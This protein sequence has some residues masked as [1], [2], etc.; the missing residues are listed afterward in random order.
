M[1]RL[2][3]EEVGR[4]FLRWYAPYQFPN[5]KVPCCVD[6]R[7]DDP[8]PENDSHGEFIFLVSELYRYTH[9][10]SLLEAMWPHVEAAAGYMETLRQSERSA[11]NHAPARRAFYGL[12][13]ASISHEPWRKAM[14]A[15][16][17]WPYRKIGASPAQASAAR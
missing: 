15:R 6:A 13:P 7:G 16:W 1:L 9:D 10:R 2:G 3:H 8:V 14:R 4:D 12:L 17:S 11:A 5:G